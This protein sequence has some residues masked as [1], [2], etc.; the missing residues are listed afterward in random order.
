M[1]TA[2]NSSWLGRLPA[3]LID[4]ISGANNATMSRAK[5]KGYRLGL[6]NERTMLDGWDY[7]NYFGQEFNM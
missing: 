5:A 7:S 2:D 1:L 6:M 4:M 3:E